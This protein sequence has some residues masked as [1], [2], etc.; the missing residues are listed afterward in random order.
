MELY[1]DIES[2]VF[3]ED[4]KKYSIKFFRVYYPKRYEIGALDRRIRDEIYEFKN[5]VS[6]DKFLIEIKEWLIENYGTYQ[7]NGVIFLPIPASNKKVNEK[8]YKKFCELLCE[9]LKI[10]NGYAYISMKENNS[11]NH[12]KDDM[13]VKKYEFILN[14]D[15]LKEKYLIVFDDILTSGKTFYSLATNLED[16]NCKIILAIFLARTIK[17]EDYV[18]EHFTIYKK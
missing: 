3:K 1:K 17:Q 7:L 8:R 18:E 9:E 11:P 4:N 13:K 2:L 16:L 12:L 6:F 5:G 15:K 10:E 14:K